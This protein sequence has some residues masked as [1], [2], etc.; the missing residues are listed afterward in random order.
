MEPQN[1][2]HSMFTNYVE[3]MLGLDA[4]GFPRFFLHYRPTSAGG[5]D[6]LRKMEL[7]DV[8]PAFKNFMDVKL[9][10]IKRK[11]KGNI[12]KYFRHTYFIADWLYNQG[13]GL[14]RAWS[15]E[16][17]NAV[18][19]ECVAILSEEFESF[20]SSFESV[21]KCETALSSF[22]WACLAGLKGG[23]LAHSYVADMLSNKFNHFL[24]GAVA[25]ISEDTCG[26]ESYILNEVASG[27][28][29]S[30]EGM[31]YN[32][33]R[34]VFDAIQPT[35]WLDRPDDRHTEKLPFSIDLVLTNQEFASAYAW[36]RPHLFEFEK[37]WDK[38]VLEP[39][40]EE[41]QIEYLRVCAASSCAKV[42]VP[43]HVE[44]GV[45]SNNKA[46]YHVVL[47]HIVYTTMCFGS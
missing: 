41:K 40:E 3:D 6:A 34:V 19:D 12:D 7:A 18:F 21:E 44:W 39:L 47:D 42:V 15:P 5:Y 33:Y 31:P 1:A 14:T 11:S 43:T 36:E 25:S 46:L 35:Y 9:P 22:L 13:R 24:W 4:E 16:I 17:R 32:L 28:L 29:Q 30:G 2:L 26:A 23:D 10:Y 27:N 38:E 8:K 37:T 45:T 20:G